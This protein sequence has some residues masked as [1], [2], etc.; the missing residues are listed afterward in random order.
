MFRHLAFRWFRW[1][2]RRVILR[3]LQE[4]SQRVSRVVTGESATPHDVTM[5]RRCEFSRTGSPRIVAV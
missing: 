1:F 3:R 5:P 4:S 2:R